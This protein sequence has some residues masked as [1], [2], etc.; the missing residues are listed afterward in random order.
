MFSTRLFRLLTLSVALFIAGCGSPASA[1]PPISILTRKY[2]VTPTLLSPV[3]HKPTLLN[4]AIPS[5]V[6]TSTT[7]PT[8]TTE[9]PSPT[10]AMPVMDMSDMTTVPLPTVTMA[11]MDMSG[12]GTELP[13][14]TATKTTME[15]FGMINMP[16]SPTATMAAMDMSGM[17]TV[18][19]SPVSG[20]AEKGKLLF[21][22]GIDKPEV[23][24]CVTCHNDDK[25]EVKVGPA[26]SDIGEHG[27]MHAAERG[28]DVETFLREAIINPNANLM[29]DPDHVFAVN[30]VSLM[31][32]SY[33]KELTEQQISDLVAYL[34]TLKENLH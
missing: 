13:L 25:D 18:P 34:L 19:T 21:R 33:G 7:V 30:G 31:Y 12:M 28:Q 15:L 29:T 24:A 11:A 22:E 2:G 1:P 23:P 26:L 10:A 27:P 14:T 4:T 17:A 8:S 3:A 20:D 32:Q 16:P 9:L 6:T 5:V